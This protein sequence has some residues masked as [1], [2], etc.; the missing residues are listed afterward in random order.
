M[1]KLNQVLLV[2]FFLSVSVLNFEIIATRISSVIFVNSYGFMILSLAIMGLAAGAIYEYYRYKKNTGENEVNSKLF[3]P[4]LYHALS[5]ILFILVVTQLEVITTPFIF[6]IFLFLPFFFAGIFYSLAFTIYSG[7]S[8][9]IYAADLTGAAAGSLMPL[10]LLSTLGP[11]N[12][13]LGVSILIL[14]VVCLLLLMAK[15]KK[16][17]RLVFSIGLLAALLIAMLLPVDFFGKVPIGEFEEK[18]FHHVYDDPTIQSNIIDSRWSVFG[19]SD[20]VEHSNQDIVKHI[21]IDGAAGSQMYRFGGSVENLG[22]MLSSMLLQFTNSVPFL[23]LEPNQKNT[24]LVIGPGGGREVL[25][26]LVSGIGSIT[27]VEINRD[28]VEIVKDES[29]YNGGLYTSFPNVNIQVK[30]GRQYVKETKRSYDLI[31]MALPSTQQLQS[32]ESYALSENYLLTVESLVDYLDILTPEGQ[33]IFTVHND[34][35]LKKLITTTIK[36][37]EKR[38]IDRQQV[39]NHFIAVEQRYSPTLVISKQPYTQEKINKYLNFAQGLSNQL[40][41]ITYAPFNWGNL[42]RTPGNN[43][44]SSLNNPR[45]QLDAIVEN[46]RYN[47]APVYDDSPYFYNLDKGIPDSF[48]LLLKIAIVFN[49]VIILIPY[50]VAARKETKQNLVKLRKLLLFFISLGAGFIFLELALFQKLIL[51]LGS[52]TISLSILL[53]SLLVGMGLGSFSGSRFKSD[54][55]YQRLFYFSVAILVAG[56]IAIFLYPVILESL[57][58]K[59]RYIRA[60]ITF[61]LILPL[62]FVLGIPFPTSIHILKEHQLDKYI[63]WMYGVNGAM[64]ILGSVMTVVV[65]MLYGF[66]LAFMAGLGFYAIIVI[67]LFSSTGIKIIKKPS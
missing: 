37:F 43:L 26:G 51:Y 61:L 60:F 65:S 30:E 18:D 57:L 49:L 56:V 2:L 23:L 11:I 50:F 36:A 12:G 14:A 31:V 54:D 16:L 4:V 63:P 5:C 48:S 35:E 34:L 28:F 33:L 46:Q 55:S 27:G 25:T 40:P 7:E 44:L 9:K 66:T 19:R 1:K 42:P 8:Y 58:G 10:V 39:L 64:T 52:P 59:D 15:S 32:I 20:L 6:F 41:A 22:P 67:V 53:C 38:G 47:I 29:D 13:I 45:L 21:F 24:M 62:G 17:A 3:L